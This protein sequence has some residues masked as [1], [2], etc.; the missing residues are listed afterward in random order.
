MASFGLK[1]ESQRSQFHSSAFSGH[2]YFLSCNGSWTLQKQ[3]QHNECRADA[4]N[5]CEMYNTCFCMA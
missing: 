4:F 3:E 2:A 5:L 1:Q